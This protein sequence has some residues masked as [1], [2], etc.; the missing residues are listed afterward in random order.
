MKIAVYTFISG[1]Y[2]TLKPFNEDYN[3]EN[4]FYFFTDQQQ[5]VKSGKY[6][7]CIVPIEKGLERYTA[8]HYKMLS[9]VLFPKYNYVI[10]LDGSVSLQENPRNLVEK[11]LSNRDIAA[12]KYPYE[13]CIYI[14]AE[15]CM[16]PGRFLRSSVEPN[17]EFYRADGFPDH[18]GLCELRVVLRKNTKRVRL[19]NEL[20]LETYKR[21]LTCD[22]LCFNY[23]LWK[24]KLKYNIIQYESLEFEK[25]LHQQYKEHRY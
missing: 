24:L 16:S 12:F 22:Q 7:T 23:C 15:N 4:D 6:Q 14:H 8:R 10:W 18:A 1:Q 19:F 3:G 17:M 2:D 5:K 21:W 9:H 25:G 13:D 20:W 11:Y